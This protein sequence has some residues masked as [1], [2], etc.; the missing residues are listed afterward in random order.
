MRSF[1]IVLFFLTASTS[2]LGEDIAGRWQGEAHVPGRSLA[3]TVDL[4]RNASGAWIGS[5]IIPEL[6]MKGAALTE[7]SDENGRIAFA[8]KG[9]GDSGDGKIIFHGALSSNETMSGDLSIGGNTAK[10]ELK[11]IGA[12]S[13][14]V[15]R[16]STPLDK[17]FEGKWVGEYAIADVPRHV[18]MTFANNANGPATAKF[19][20]V[21]KKT[22]DVTVDVVRQDAAFVVVRSNAYQIDY[23]GRLHE[24]TGQITG[25]FTQGPYE[26][27]LNL[28]REP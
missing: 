7:I 27:P 5:L 26:L 6:N 24:D 16:A 12:A 15:P 13:V 1:A 23:E 28:H 3:L 9:S 20:V 17:A 18:T 8:T 25:T 4:A 10:F 11:K 22:T 14:D 21:G 2:C 19:V